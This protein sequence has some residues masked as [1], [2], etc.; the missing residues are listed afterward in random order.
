MAKWKEGFDQ[1]TQIP[2]MSPLPTGFFV[3]HGHANYES[4]KGS[5]IE[6]T[7]Q[8]E[9]QCRELS[10]RAEPAGIYHVNPLSGDGIYDSFKNYIAKILED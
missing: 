6:I 9:Q 3:N 5:S 10:E 7:P 8:L 1:Q 2:K 4:G